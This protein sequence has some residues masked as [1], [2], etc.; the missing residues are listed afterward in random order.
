MR[1]RRDWI[2]GLAGVAI[3]ALGIAMAGTAAAMV[4]GWVNPALAGLAEAIGWVTVLFGGVALVLLF[5][6]A[7]LSLARAALRAMHVLP[8]VAP[9]E[10]DGAVAWRVALGGVEHWVCAYP[11]PTGIQV[12]ADDQPV[13]VAWSGSRGT[14]TLGGRR[15]ELTS[16]T[17]QGSRGEWVVFWI[18]VALAVLLLAPPGTSWLP[19]AGIDLQLTMRDRVIHRERTASRGGREHVGVR[20]GAEG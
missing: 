20:P 4:V 2:E 3:G 9:A 16:A 13:D 10:H 19:G 7:A 18:T 8:Q 5:L 14:F 11:S 17:H 12:F 6:A 15:A 1:R